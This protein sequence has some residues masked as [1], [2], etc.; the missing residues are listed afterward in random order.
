MAERTVPADTSQSGASYYEILGVAR[1]A[2]EKEIA[3]AYKRLALK[4]HPDRNMV[5]RTPLKCMRV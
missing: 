1:N 4:Y 2:T 3:S 5:G